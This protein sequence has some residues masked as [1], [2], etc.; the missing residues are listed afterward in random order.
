M[1]SI[2][3]QLMIR[4]GFGIDREQLRNHFIPIMEHLEDPVDVALLLK[5]DLAHINSGSLYRLYHELM[6]YELTWDRERY[7][8]ESHHVINECA[9]NERVYQWVQSIIRRFR[10]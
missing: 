2:L 3:D 8:Y 4:Q 10:N 9:S 5:P 1:S 6:K 7:L